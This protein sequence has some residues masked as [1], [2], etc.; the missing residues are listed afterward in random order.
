MGHYAGS[1]VQMPV[2]DIAKL[3]QCLT[4]TSLNGGT[5]ECIDEW[6]KSLQTGVDKSLAIANR[7]CSA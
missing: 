4:D 5:D 6:H 7:L 1:C 2:R 3:R